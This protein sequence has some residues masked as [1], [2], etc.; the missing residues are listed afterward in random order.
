M[1]STAIEKQRT[2]YN[3]QSIYAV[4][5]WWLFSGACL[6]YLMAAF[7][8]QTEVLTDHVYYNSLAARF[9]A[10]KI[11]SFIQ[12]Q[13]RIGMITYWT[14]PIGLFVKLLFSS[15]CIIAGLS[16]TSYRLPF[17][18]VF[19]IALVAEAAF[20]CNTLLQLLL[21]SLFHNVNNLEDLQ[22]FAPLSLFSIIHGPS[23]PGYL[24]YPLQTINV[25]EIIYCLLLAAGLH[26]F[27]K[28]PFK[29]LIALVLSSYG[30]GLLCWLIFFVF[31]SINFNL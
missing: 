22:S 14:I 29:K 2:T 19:K 26:F 9:T 25:F 10:G 5:G 18:T 13:H 23:I 21:L 15:F 7:Y 8:I 3:L 28:A 1:A 17:K 4:N 20:V 6:I 16:F 27:L 12:A 11:E 24:Q 30:I 31:M